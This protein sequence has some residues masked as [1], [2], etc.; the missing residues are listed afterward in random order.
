MLIGADRTKK[1]RVGSR[2]CPFL[3][4]V[5]LG[6][7]A[8]CASH[9]A[10]TQKQHSA[11]FANSP[12]AGLDTLAPGVVHR[13]VPTSDGAGIDL[14]D[15]DLSRAKARP[16]I[17]ARGVRLSGGSVVGQAWTPGE[18]LTKTQALAAIN[19]GYFGRE[20]GG[21]DKEIVG[22]LAQKGRVRHAAPPLYGQG[23]ANAPRGFYRRSAFGLLPGGMPSIRWAA[24]EPESPQALRAYASP[25]VS[26]DKRGT[27]WS[28]RAAVG[29]GPMLIFKGAVVVSDRQERLVSPGARAR[30]FVAYDNPGGSPRHFALG[31]ASGMTFQDLAV[32]LRGYFLKYD[33]T[34]AFSAMCLDG[35]E[36]TQMTYRQGKTLQTPRETGVSVPDAVVLLPR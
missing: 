8:G 12:A 28:V 32:F 26:Q 11:I 31:I 17:V 24:T 9:S 25:L 18:W 1:R 35:G 5:V 30:T 23:G 6:L 15:V 14:I 16:A 10:A 13:A 27:R 4:V 22:L 3:C 19:G 33:R 21:G 34:Q 7:L 2:A 20:A 36:S 29:C